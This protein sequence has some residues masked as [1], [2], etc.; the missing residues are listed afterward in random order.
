M[1]DLPEHGHEAVMLRE[2]MALLDPKPGEVVMDC[3]VGRG[4]HALA[5]A[6]R[7]SPGGM[8]IALDVDPENLLYAR[9]GSKP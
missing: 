3:T 6:Q 9:S 2:V 1:R 5:I 4:G 7:I 8:L